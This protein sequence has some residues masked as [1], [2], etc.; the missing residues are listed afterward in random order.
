MV[1]SGWETTAARARVTTAAGL[2]EAPASGEAPARPRLL[3]HVSVSTKA[4]AAPGA[5]ARRRRAPIARAARPSSASRS[6]PRST[7]DFA[8]LRAVASTR[9]RASAE[10]TAK[11]G[12]ATDASGGRSS[13]VEH[14]EPGSR[15]RLLRAPHRF[16]APRSR[17]NSRATRAPT[18]TRSSAT[19][20]TAP[21]AVVPSRSTSART[22][23]KRRVRRRLRRRFSAGQSLRR[24]KRPATSSRT[25]RPATK[26]ACAPPNALRE[27]GAAGQRIQPHAVK[28]PHECAAAACSKQ[29]TSFAE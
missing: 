22:E 15:A 7:A 12:T 14:P 6:A 10:A 1:P 24:A 29:L 18:A 16:P 5:I 4:H 11:R 3:R 27:D 28:A 23:G 9:P 8:R 20:T 2:A 13:A 19:R 25:C 21:P 17:T 26:G